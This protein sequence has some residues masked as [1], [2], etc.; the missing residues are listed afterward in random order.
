MRIRIMLLGLAL[1]FSL[2]A[3]GTQAN[4][5]AGAKPTSTQSPVG[6]SD[7]VSVK[8]EQSSLGNIL[9]D[10]NGRTLY[11]FVNDKAGGSNK[12][13]GS[14]CTEQCIATW[15]ALTSLQAATAGSG[16]DHTLLSQIKRTEG[17]LQVTYG[18]W[19]LYYYVGDVGPGDVDGQGV[20]GVWF[21]VGADGKLIK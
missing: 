20:N 18:G 16:V 9:V 19:P 13:G 1:I 4:N 10:Q 3:C 2:A 21:V 12:A 11:A 15:P 14:S 5:G 6:A 8:V 7:T 17:S